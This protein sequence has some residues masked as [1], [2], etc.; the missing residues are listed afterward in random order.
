MFTGCENFSFK[1]RLTKHYLSLSWNYDRLHLFMCFGIF[2]KIIVH[3]GLVS[4]PHSFA[5]AG[6]MKITLSILERSWK[7]K[8][9]QFLDFNQ[10][11]GFGIMH[12]M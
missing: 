8:K 7:T 4:K 12:D 6:P 9:P 11:P 2:L 1:A 3:T 10:V 5:T